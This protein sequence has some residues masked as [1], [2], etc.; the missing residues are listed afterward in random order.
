MTAKPINTTNSIKTTCSYC[1]VGCGIIVHKGHNGKLS[2]EGDSEHPVNLGMLCS[3]GMNLHHVAQDLSDRFLYPEMRWAKNLPRVRVD[4][5]QAMNRAVSTVKTMISK[6]GPDSIGFYVSGQCLTEEY[7][8][9]NKLA[10]G[11]LGTNNID[12]NSRL[13]MSSAVAGYKLALGEDAVP[14]S[15]D[16][17]ELADCFFIAGA[18]PA[19]C[20]PILYRR[21]EAHKKANPNV[22]IIVVD[23]RVTQTCANADLHLQINPGTDVYLYNAIA[24]VLIENGDI[25]AEFIQKYTSGFDSAK[26]EILK[27]TVMEA[28]EICGVEASAIKKAAS[29]IAQAKGFISMWAMGLNQSVI[30]VNKNLALI[31]LSILTGHIGKPGSGPFSLTGQPNAMGGREVGGMA[32]LL[33]AHRN[34]ADPVH[35][36]EVAAFWG[37]DSIPENPGYTAT[38]MF[39]AILADKLKVIWI[40]CTNPLVS[41]P[42]AR[43][44]EKALKMAK[45][46]I[47]QDISRNSITAQYADI[48]FPATTWLEK[49]GTMTNSERRIS[50]LP[51]LMD[52]PGETLSD[53]DILCRFAKEMDFKGFDYKNQDEIFDEHVKLTANTNIDISG[54]SYDWL[55]KNGSTQWPFKLGDT[56]G[57][58]RLFTDKQFYTPDKKAKLFGI[59]P[60][61]LSESINPDFPLVLTTGR[62]RDHWHTMTK[63][64]KVNKLGTHIAEAYLEIN[65]TDAAAR[66]LTDNSL[67]EV[68]NHR[69]SVRIKIIITETIKPGV[70]FLP[71]HWGKILNSDTHRANNLTNNLVD[72]RSKEPDFK[73]AAVQVKLFEKPI[74]HIVV[75]GAG[76]A[77][78]RFIVDYRALNKTDKI[79]VFS[80]EEN[81]FYNRIL[82]PE[83]VSGHKN[84]DDLVKITREE[85]QRL[86]IHV[87]VGNPISSIDPLGKKA[88]DCYGKTH[89]FD[90]LILATGSRPN[91]PAGLPISGDGI[92]TIRSREDADYLRQYMTGK[93]SVLIMGGGLL[94]LEIASSFVGTPVKTHL[95]HRNSL[96]MD[97]QLD[98]TASELL[99]ESIL[100]QG[101]SVY[102]DEELES[103]SGISKDS[104]YTVQ[105]K[106]GRRIMVNAIIYAI[107]TL[108]N[109]ELGKTSGLKTNRG[110]VVN[111]RLQTSNP[112]IYALGEIAEWNGQL[113]GITPAAEQQ[114]SIAAQ[115]LAGDLAAVYKGSVV[116]NILKFP[117]IELCSVGLTKSPNT[118]EYEEVLFIDKT[119]R[120]YKKC[121]IR[122]DRLVGTILLGDKGEFT[123]FKNL[124]EKGTELSDKRLKLLRSGQTPKP[125]KGKLICSCN[126]VGEGNIAD[127]IAKG[128]LKLNELCEAST[129]GTGCGSC[130]PEVQAILEKTIKVKEG[131]L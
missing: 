38:E 53:V 39:E 32:N 105:L 127:E 90:T 35:R 125:L 69:G 16:D 34:L 26:D 23:P 84:W 110:I 72:S 99:T 102:F 6:Y 112:N 37:V 106:S 115:S 59:E 49:D 11:F 33:P 40:I 88:I 43:M 55:R 46:V 93:N 131:V 15:Y 109:I 101:V 12:T 18:N 74:E 45:L 126:N 122:N 20:H 36:A 41:L 28:A 30:G 117:G 94:G 54:L 75:V 5:S 19:W 129:A 61:N 111:G 97:K 76:A 60:Q 103:I 1:G 89:S 50:Y 77:A 119:N 104:T 96:L 80:K 29:Y 57:T 31:N 128:T 42:D 24:R 79:T 118:T 114:A 63:T 14:I 130:K 9:V 124:I 10:K 13:C 86:N 91:L 65:P 17:I 48:I 92:F 67:V 2:V 4:W 108:P 116:L 52:A 68:S 95:V 71:M 121:I 56:S 66:D 62:I 78:Y 7:Y 25:D 3:K 58:E 120:Y 81:P 70:V 64:G 113:F 8:I 47:V 85:Y 27:T 44:V 87:E 51:Q 123:E 73:F 82:L 107:G 83:Y 98:R 22:K 21:L 100:E